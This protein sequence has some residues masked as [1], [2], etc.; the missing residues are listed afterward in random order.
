MCN[1]RFLETCP[2]HTRLIKYCQVL[3][4]DIEANQ[5]K[6]VFA[7]CDDF[8]NLLVFSNESCFLHTLIC[9]SSLLEFTWCAGYQ[10]KI[11]HAQ[12]FLLTIMGAAKQRG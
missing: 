6:N 11:V 1:L 5:Q 3:G 7:H 8:V 9:T 2:L 4:E 12:N 10:R